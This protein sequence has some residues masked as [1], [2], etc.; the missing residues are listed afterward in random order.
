MIVHRP[1]IGANYETGI[2]GKK[3]AIVGNSHW[4]KVADSDEDGFTEMVV[5]GVTEGYRLRFFSSIPGYFDQPTKG[6]WDQVLF[7]NYAPRAIGEGHERYDKMT[8]AMAEEGKARFSGIL[9]THKP[10]KV[11]VF[12]DSIRWALPPMHL[13]DPKLP[14]QS[15]RIGKLLN[16]D[17]A[18]AIFLLRHTQG[19]P[20]QAMRETVASLMMH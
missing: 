6:F 4:L 17:S 11:F 20:K 12:S 14:I 18:P 7:F 5:A 19:A 15:A 9:S 10:D 3:V 16:D 1:W 2:A 8:S 13:A